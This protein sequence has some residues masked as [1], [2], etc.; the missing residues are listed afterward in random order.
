MAKKLLWGLL[1]IMTVGCAVTRVTSFKDPAFA[2]RKIDQVLIVV[3]STDLEARTTIETAFTVRFEDCGVKAIPSFKVFIPTRTYT[4]D[5][6]RKSIK[7]HFIAAVL[8][9]ELKDSTPDRVFLPGG[10][11]FTTGQISPPQVYSTSPNVHVIPGPQTFSAQSFSIGPG[12]ISKPKLQYKIDLWDV[13]TEKIIWTAASVT[14]GG[15]EVKFNTLIESFANTV[16]EKLKE[17]GLI[18]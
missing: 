18:K 17:D 11:G 2:D 4:E 13:A 1:I 6:I 7:D 15:S 5:E 16:L 9:I 10:F 12:V 3:P 8:W 14:R